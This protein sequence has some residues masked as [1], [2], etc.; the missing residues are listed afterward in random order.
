MK[1]IISVLLAICLV[2]TGCSKN[3]Q[4]AQSSSP[5]AKSE[6]KNEVVIGLVAEIFGTQSFND[7]ILSGIENLNAKYG[8]RY[9]TLEVPEVSDLANS[10][11]TLIS[12]GV[13]LIVVGSAIYEDAMIEVA[14]EYPNVKF[15]YL[16]DALPGYKNIASTVYA[17]QEGA[18]LIGAL[19]GL[20]TKTDNVGSV[21]AIK[22]DTVQERFTY[23]FTAGAKYVNPSV[24]VQNG[25]TNSYSDINKGGEIASVMYKKGADIVSTFAGACNLGV[26]NAANDA[27]DG[28]YCFGAAKGQFD[29]MPNKIIASLVKPVDQTVETVIG[30]YI[31]SGELETDDILS[32]G[33]S[34]NGVIV[35]YTNMNDE[36]LKLITPEI[37]AKLDEIKADILS[38]KIVP[39]QTEQEYKDFRF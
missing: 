4:T 26:F 27:G 18:F 39:P 3:S 23:G 29:K 33:L 7:D 28:K 10:Y 35:R 20:L 5:E 31:E 38:G 25:Y 37:Q 8:T 36:L 11:R 22:G 32:L 30:Q 16:A 14:E 12:Q 17:E 19:A 9:I 1:R 15:L 24:T 13:N 2:F 21:A 6:A 34:N